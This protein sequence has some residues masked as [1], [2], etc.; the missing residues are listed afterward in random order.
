MFFVPAGFSIS[1]RVHA[2]PMQ[3]RPPRIVPYP[4]DT[5]DGA[6]STREPVKPAGGRAIAGAPSTPEPVKPFGESRMMFAFG[7]PE[8]M[9][10]VEDAF[11][12]FALGEPDPID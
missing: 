3:A 1:P 2:G 6:P 10:A 4:P 8:P 12:I 7:G 9:P 5:T 11:P